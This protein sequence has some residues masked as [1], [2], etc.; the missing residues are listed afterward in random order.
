MVLVCPWETGQTPQMRWVMNQ[1]SRGSLP[2][3][4]ISKPRNR[5]PELQASLTLPFSS[6]TSMRRCPS[7]RGIGSITTRF[8]MGS[9]SRPASEQPVR[10]FFESSE[11]FPRAAF[12]TACPTMA[13][14]VATARPT[15]ILSAVRSP[16]GR[17]TSASFP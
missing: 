9:P 15:P 7:M 4:M 10:Y 13:A 12:T 8:A 2:C 5:V 14:P 3:R 6:S 17:A 11:L 1:A 16:Y